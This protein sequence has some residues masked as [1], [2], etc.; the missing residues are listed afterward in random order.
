MEFVESK[1]DLETTDDGEVNSHDD[2]PVDLPVV[3]PN[4]FPAALRDNK[5]HVEDNELS[6]ISKPQSTSTFGL[7]EPGK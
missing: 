6:K 2:P 5:T 3:T 1:N 7:G 4:K